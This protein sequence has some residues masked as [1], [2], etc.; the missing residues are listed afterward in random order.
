[1][2][3]LNDK[4]VGDCLLFYRKNGAGYTL[5]INEAEEFDQLDAEKTIPVSYTH[6]RAHE[7]LRYLDKYRMWDSEYLKSI[8]E[9]HIN[10]ERLDYSKEEKAEG[11]E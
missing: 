6:L 4:W 5:N 2:L 10:N 3:S 11:G 7:T 1:M 8:A 9:F